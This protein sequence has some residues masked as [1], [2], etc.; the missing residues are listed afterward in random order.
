MIDFIS[1]TIF[2]KE[3]C[4]Y[5][6]KLNSG[7]KN[8]SDSEVPVAIPNKRKSKFGKVIDEIKLEE[9]ILPK[10]KKFGI[11]SLKNSQPM[12]IQ[13]NKGDYFKPHTDTPHSSDI[14][15]HRI[16]TLII[17]LSNSNE[18]NGGELYVENKMGS[19]ELGSVIIFR[20]NKIHELRE[21]KS[22]HRNILVCMFP[23][24]D[25]YIEKSTII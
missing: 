3:D 17:Q 23:S 16:Y 9:I 14:S 5:I 18:Y 13:Y 12:F 22:G 24:N 2:S 7:F 6:L 4:D 1:E 11:L 21:V 10:I 20:S 19:R 8:F 25:L 15:T